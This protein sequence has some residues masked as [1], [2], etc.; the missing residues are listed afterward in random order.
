[1]DLMDALRETLKNSLIVDGVT[2]GLLNLRCELLQ[3]TD[4]GTGQIFEYCDPIKLHIECCV[5]LSYDNL[6]GLRES[7]K[8]LDKREALL[9]VLAESTDEKNILKLVEAL[10]REHGINLIKVS[11]SV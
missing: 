8:K 1:M 4:I 11:S 7:V 5:L 6:A 9:C 3:F 10:C 2:K